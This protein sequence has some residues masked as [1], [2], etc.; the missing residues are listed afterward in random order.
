VVSLPYT[1]CDLAKSTKIPSKDAQIRVNGVEVQIWCNLGLIK[2]IT[3][4]GKNYFAFIT[5][6]YS[7]HRN[8]EALKTKDEIQDVLTR[9]VDRIIASLA[10][11]SKNNE[12]IRRRLQVIRIDE[13]L[14]FSLK[15]FEKHYNRHGI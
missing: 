11:L 3:I 5:D 2:P 10:I 4:S 9:Y 8:F 14:K 15:A 12:R 1:A 6:D 13:G 7:R